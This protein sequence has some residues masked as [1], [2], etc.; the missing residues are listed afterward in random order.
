MGKSCGSDIGDIAFSMKICFL[1]HNLRQD[2]G[3]G[4]FS[5]R[6]ITGLR[7]ALSSDIVALTTVPRGESY[8]KAVLAPNKLRL[9]GQILRVRALMRGCDVIHAFDAFPYGLIAAVASLGLR[10]KLILTVI[11]S[12]SIL[13]FYR[14]HYAPL[15]RWVY[16][17]ADRITAISAF[18]RGE[19]LKKMPQLE[20]MVINPGVDADVFTKDYGVYDVGRFKPYLLSVGQLRWRKG[21]HFS[22][23][24]FAR[25]TAMFPNLHYVIVGKR[26][27]DV[28]YTRLQKLITEL[29]LEG[30][31]HIIE[32]IDTRAKLADL[33]RGAELFCLFSQNVNHDVEGFGQVFLEAAAAGLPVVGSKNCGVD[34]AVRDGENGI[35]VPTRSPDDFA[36][37]ILAILQDPARKKA[38]AG[39]SVAFARQMRWERQIESYATLYRGLISRVS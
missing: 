34:D 5:R 22:I 32:D 6:L 36:D 25:I 39:A 20:I 2:N 18:T 1:T 27:S 7:D 21:Y 31:V 12:G 11:G 4:V 15:I 29:K 26:Y 16:R 33:Y 37:A 3:A 30:R 13:P 19:I 28:Y 23:R 9:A 10:K 14:W 8:E 17:R 24:A 35:L 38:M